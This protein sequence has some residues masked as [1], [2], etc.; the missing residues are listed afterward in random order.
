MK[1]ICID[2]NEVFNS[3]TINKEY[4]CLEI[5]KYKSKQYEYSIDIKEPKCIET[6]L[7]YYVI[8]DDTPIK[9]EYPID[10]FITIDEYRN[11]KLEEIGI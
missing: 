9:C 7:Y 11:K 3:I 1:V 8:I 2:N 5:K 6:E 4:E 10:L